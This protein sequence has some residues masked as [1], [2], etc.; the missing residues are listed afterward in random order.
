M[1]ALRLLIVEADRLWHDLC[2]EYLGWRSQRC[3]ILSDCGDFKHHMRLINSL[4]TRRV[5]KRGSFDFCVKDFTSLYAKIPLGDLKARIG[6]FTKFAFE[7]A[8]LS[9][10][11]FDGIFVPRSGAKVRKEEA[12]WSRPG[13]NPILRMRCLLMLRCWLPG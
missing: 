9:K 3:W 7:R 11:G 5:I 1:E 12:A 10:S 2:L 8:S 4:I 13:R 6:G